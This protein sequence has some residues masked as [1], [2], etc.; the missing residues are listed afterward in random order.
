MTGEKIIS[1][2]KKSFKDD[3]Y[4]T[5]EY[6]KDKTGVFITAV[7]IFATFLVFG[8]KVVSYLI[9]NVQYH[10]WNLDEGFLLEDNTAYLKLGV[11][12]MYVML[13]IAANVIAKKYIYLWELY[14][15]I[16]YLFKKTFKHNKK[17]LNESTKESKLIKK[18][19]N[20]ILKA[21]EINKNDE[22]YPTKA[23][24]LELVKAGIEK[25]EENLKILFIG[26][27]MSSLIGSMLTMETLELCCFGTAIHPGNIDIFHHIT[28]LI[29][30]M[31]K[32]RRLLPISVNIL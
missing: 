26:K 6:L 17:R 30:S 29:L 2:L 28:E 31:R 14:D 21:D 3:D 12:T 27:Y 10:Y 16:V 7:S 23:E 19:Y 18:L 25:Q 32:N 1:N 8:S 24:D 9:A 11:Y 20:A 22:S 13:A 5:I 15:C 4:R